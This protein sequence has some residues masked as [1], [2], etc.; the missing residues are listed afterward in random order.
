[1]NQ[2]N[3][4]AGSGEASTRTARGTTS[5]RGPG[6]KIARA[7]RR[8]LGSGIA[9]GLGGG[10]LLRRGVRSLRRGAR[11]RGLGQLLVGG[12]FL[13]LARRQRRS[14]GGVDETDVVDTG[15][16][17]EEGAGAGPELDDDTESM[18]VDETDVV[19]TG[20]ADDL[21]D[22]ERET[23]GSG[24][25]RRLGEAALDGESGRVPVPQRAFN[26]GLLSL[27]SDAVWG[28]RE[29]DP[30]VLVSEEYDAIEELA[31][32]RYVASSEIDDDRGLIVPDAVRDHW[33][34]VAGGGT[35]VSGGD[36]I[37]FA[38]TEAFRAEG[39]VLVVPERWS[40]EVLGEE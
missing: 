35:A 5:G 27:G 29:G 33:D 12:L 15:P 11:A 32:V 28:V 14:G 10:L 18:P 1:M 2:T 22:V 9:A 21:D 17:V 30:A 19:D 20:V 23:D 3:A 39:H 40:E 38:T 34:E 7:A 13:S 31:G 6:A 16:D 4:D 36:G 8:A 25:A 26:Q 24:E 37:V